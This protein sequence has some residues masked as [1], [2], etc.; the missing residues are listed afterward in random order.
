MVCVDYGILEGCV[1][2]VSGALCVDTLGMDNRCVDS[3]ECVW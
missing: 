2:V 3:A 1:R